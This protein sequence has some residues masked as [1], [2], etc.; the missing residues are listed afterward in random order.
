M[1]LFTSKQVKLI[2]KYTIENEPVSSIDLMERAASQCTGWLTNKFSR[3]Y[4]FK[5]FTGHGNNGG[6]G[7]AI[8][9]LLK[10]NDYKVEV[11]LIK[12]SDKLSSD[13]SKNLE[14][15]LK[16]KIAHV[17]E[18]TKSDELPQINSDDVTIDALFGSGLSRPLSGLAA[19]T[20]EYLNRCPGYKVAIDVPSGL[21]GEGIVHGSAV[22][23]A[24]DTLTFQFPFLSFLYAENENYVG[25]WHVLKIGL[26]PQIINQIPSKYN[27]AEITDISIKKRPEFGHKGTFGHALLI[28]GSS[29]MA[30][31]AILS[32]KACLRSGCGLVT[33][34]VPKDIAAIIHTAFPESL[35]S[36]DISKEKFSLLPDISKFSAIGIGPGIGTSK[37]SIKAL[38]ELLEKCDKPLLLDADALN[39][40]STNK[41]LLK[42]IPRNSILTPH[43]GEFDRLFGKSVNSYERMLK[44]IEKTKE[45]G[46]CI[47]LK[48]HYSSTVLPDGTCYFNTTGN[49]GMATGGSGD[50]LTGIILSLLAQGYDAG[51]AAI[52]GVFIHG[53]AGDISAE[54]S[55][56][57]ALIAS[58]IINCI[59]KAF[60][61]IKLVKD[62]K[63]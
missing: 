45:L 49:S 44:Q 12:I 4:T 13:A 36:T 10:Q 6:D 32:S 57:E 3:N 8:A 23:M 33:T 26:H 7:L 24:N 27:L 52:N 55:G 21:P 1:K 41:K 60:I 53:M 15:L 37:E 17:K 20:I 16:N 5:I 50:V 62:E 2:D 14:L 34:H 51:T 59:G 25:K 56:F 38:H 30:G 40:V 9:R 31:A 22:F 18:I 42:L 19:E 29:G 11:Y 47:V 48:G 39:I 58:D 61:K 46:F 63:N 35:V 43:P 28:A 54:E